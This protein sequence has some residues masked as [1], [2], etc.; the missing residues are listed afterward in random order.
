MRIF[1]VNINFYFLL[2]CIWNYI[3]ERKPLKYKKKIV[4][5]TVRNAQMNQTVKK[6]TRTETRHNA[7]FMKQT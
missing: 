3:W 1:A 2:K 6:N 7:E 5:E 4:S